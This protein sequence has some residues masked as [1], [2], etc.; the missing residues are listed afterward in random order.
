MK[1]RSD[2]YENYYFFFFKE[3]HKIDEPKNNLWMTE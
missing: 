2:K 1:H 3:H